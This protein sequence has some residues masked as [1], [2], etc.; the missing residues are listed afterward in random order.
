MKRGEVWDANLAPATGHE[1]DGQRPVV[2]LSADQFNS[3]PLELV[4][5]L[6]I[7]SG[8][9]PFPSR[10]PV[11]APEGGL[12]GTSYVIC[13]QPRTISTKRLQRLRGRLAPQTM[14]RIST[15]VRDI[16]QL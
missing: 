8:G 7:T 13:E 6:P 12:N 9:Q 1:Q 4:V 2:I 11:N 15:I 14:Q 3:L 5:I 16:L 10:I